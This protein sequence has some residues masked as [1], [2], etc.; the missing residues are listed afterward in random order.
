MRFTERLLTAE[1]LVGSVA[2]LL[3]QYVPGVET[4]D[5]TATDKRAAWTKAMKSVLRVLA[6]KRGLTMETEDVSVH[7]IDRQLEAYLQRH[8]ALML[9]VLSAWGDRREVESSFQ[10]L[11]RLK[12]PQKML[13]YTCTKWQEAV[14]EQLTAA[15]MRYPYHVEG[16]QYIALNIIGSEAKVIGTALNVPHSG[17]L[18]LA[19]AEFK[20]LPGSPFLLLRA[21]QAG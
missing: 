5:A 2:R 7:G 15:I 12:S 18:T 14:M 17:T 3:L 9:A 13:V 16:E 19:E 11:L 10:R 21:R 6:E 20:T 4:G 8:E 1:E